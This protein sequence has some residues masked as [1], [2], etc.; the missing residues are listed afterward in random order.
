MCCAA[1]ENERQLKGEI[2]HRL[3][4]ALVVALLAAAPSAPL[5]AQSVA[6][7][8]LKA[9]DTWTY[10]WS[11]AASRT[12]KRTVKNVSADRYRIE[13]TADGGNAAQGEDA[14][15]RGFSMTRELNVIAR[16]PQNADKLQVWKWLDWPL[17]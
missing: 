6:A 17:E 11:G 13:Q 9:G 1:I 14:K 7:P 5:L 8:E 10:R 12:E 16:D 4:A 2:M 3:L 15:E